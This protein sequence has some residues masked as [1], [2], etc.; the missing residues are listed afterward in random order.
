M[1]GDH[2]HAILPQMFQAR[3]VGAANLLGNLHAVVGGAG[4]CGSAN[5]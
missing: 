3:P 1:Y 2:D 4:L 5:N